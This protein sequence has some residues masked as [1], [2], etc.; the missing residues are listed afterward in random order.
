MLSHRV[1]MARA[2]ADP[3]LNTWKYSRTA[4]LYYAAWDIFDADIEGMVWDG[5]TSAGQ[6]EAYS[7]DSLSREYVETGGFRYTYGRTL[8]DTGVDLEYFKICKTNAGAEA[9]SAGD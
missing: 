9:P 3:Y 2:S 8:M 6:G 7:T 5:V 1:L 4:P